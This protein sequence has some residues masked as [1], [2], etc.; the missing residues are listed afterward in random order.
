M[1]KDDATGV[2]SIVTRLAVAVKRRLLLWS[3]HD[4]ELTDDGAE[5][6]LVTGVK[7]LTWVTGTRIIA[8][9]TGSYVL[10]D[11][12]TG[13]VKDIQGPGSIGGVTGQETGRFG[14]VGVA[15]MGYMGMGG[16]VPRPLATRLCEGEVLLAKDINTH[17]INTDGAS[18][19]RRQIP[20]AVA[21]EAIGYS[22]P[23]LLAL[24][25]GKGTLEI[26]NPETLSALQS[27]NL[28]NP[29]MMHVP[30]PYVSLAHAGKGFL[31]ASDK[32][33]WRMDALGYDAQIDVLIES[34]QYDEA[35]SLLSMLEDALLSDK[36]G[37]TRE[38]KML[39]A[40]T[41][42]DR[43]KYRASLDL[44]TEAMAPPDRVIGMFPSVIS[45]DLESGT[46]IQEE[47][48]PEQ[49]KKVS[50]EAPASSKGDGDDSDE[51]PKSVRSQAQSLLRSESL[52]L[53]NSDT[54]STV[55][56]TVA[57][58]FHRRD[59]EGK[60]LKTATIELLGFLVDART[61]L[62]GRLNFD[63]SLKQSSEPN[64][65]Q[66]F[67]DII[68]ASSSST[69]NA[70]SRAELL[71]PI[72]K[73]VD[74]TL[75]RAYMLARPT[76]AGALFRLP[77]FCD[78]A[79]VKEKLLET[80]RYV[81]LVDF[82]YGKKLHAEALEMLLQF[83]QKKDDDDVP[84]A[85]RGPQRTVAYL[86]SLGPQDVDLVLK[87]AD[88]PITEDKTLGMEVFVAD[89]ENAETLP[90][91]RV[92]EFLQ[93]KDRELEIRYL[94]HIVQELDDPTPAFHQR[95]VDIYLV[96]IKAEV[97]SHED[98]EHLLEKFQE[99]L[100]SSKHYEAWTVLRGLSKDGML[101][102]PRPYGQS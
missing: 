27:I 58:S 12:E 43:R 79:V 78:P 75:F 65:T 25:P 94:E 26:R 83:G 90:R 62:Q 6:T 40:Q 28:P 54:A 15:S 1:V 85:L 91:E 96:R 51:A 89:T 68:L 72:A 16:M 71:L 32:C 39:K 86:Q 92:V 14:G 48:K 21:P 73:L 98:K 101:R 36:D 66:S 82:F 46:E 31:V 77:N 49:S 81:D 74:T 35:I 38:A 57:A 3:W 8:G 24:Q 41:L 47:D 69:D 7:S 33:V 18:L 5:W 97:T 67:I 99:F 34:G 60:D 84:E 88:W 4:S 23:Y 59:L 19:G 44:F 56:N 10:V 76:L 50:K 29:T 2:P 9:L 11:V 55:S 102:K 13:E 61:K 64:S 52:V 17:F 80:K 45:G 100:K 42:F 63:G 30:N 70:D 22:Y 20:W 53:D 93:M 95:L 87:Y 37:R